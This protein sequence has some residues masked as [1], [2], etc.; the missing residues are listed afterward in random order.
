MALSFYVRHIYHVLN[1]GHF[2][3][4]TPYC[5]GIKCEQDAAGSCFIRPLSMNTSLVLSL[6]SV[7]LLECYIY[8]IYYIQTY[9]ESLQSCFQRKEVNEEHH[10]VQ[11]KWKMYFFTA[12]N[13][14]PTC[15]IYKQIIAMA[16]EYNI[17]R[18]YTS[19]HASKYDEYSGKLREGKVRELE[20]SLKKQQSVFKCVYQTND[21][22]VQASYR[23]AQEIAVSS[24]PFSE[25]FKEMYV[26]GC[27]RY[28]P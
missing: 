18:H 2:V 11:E 16:K 26:I 5:T 12:V 22:A 1:N 13:G 6:E 7:G 4:S 20:Q 9:F 15:L 24:K 28:L 23:I 17:H 10:V 8:S 25:N 27:G 19:T 14:K 3:V 21:V